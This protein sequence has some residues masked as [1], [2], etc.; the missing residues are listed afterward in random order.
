MQH[1]AS[2]NAQTDR[3]RTGRRPVLAAATTAGLLG[4]ASLT[5][6]PALAEQQKEQTPTPGTS[7]QPVVVVMD[8]SESMLEKDADEKG[9]ARI[10]A[11][12]DATKDL[13]EKTPEDAKLGM[14]AF[15]HAD[16]NT[17]TKI[18]TLQ[19][20]AKVDAKKLTKKVDALDAQGGTPLG[21]SLQH[22]ADELKD[23]EGEKSIVLVSDGE[24]TCD[25]P[26]ACEIAQQLAE[27]GIDLTVHTIGFR[28]QGNTKAQETLECIAEATGGTYSSAD[29]AEQLTETLTTQTTRALQGY[30]TAGTPVEGGAS[31]EDAPR[32]SA[33]QFTDTIATQK[34]E[35]DDGEESASRRYYRIPYHKGYTPVVTATVVKDRET[36]EMLG[37]SDVLIR[38]VDLSER[39]YETCTAL[40]DTVVPSRGSGLH[41]TVHWFEHDVFSKELSEDTRDNCLTKDDEVVV[42]V[43]HAA[44]TASDEEIPLE[45]MV[46]YAKQEK[47]SGS[48][49]PSPKFK[50]VKT[51]KAEQV[52]GGGSFNDATPIESG[53]TITDTLVPGEAKYFQIDAATNQTLAARVD[54]TSDQEDNLM[55]WALAYNPLREHMSFT[56]DPDAGGSGVD[57]TGDLSIIGPGEGSYANG[58]LEE[59]I[60]PNRR[61][62]SGG[63]EAYSVP[64][65]QYIKVQRE[66]DSSAADVPQS[67]E[68]TVDVR[69]EAEKEAGEFITTNAEYTEAFGEDSDTGREEGA[70]REDET[71]REE[72]TERDDADESDDT[73]REEDAESSDEA[74]DTDR[75]EESEPSPSEASGSEDGEEPSSGTDEQK[76]KDTEADVQAAE[77]QDSGDI[78]GILPWA[79]GG[80][81]VIALAGGGII[82]AGRRG[83]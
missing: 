82:L 79:I 60:H 23:V 4:L 75:E 62:S 1:Q 26:P 7:Q 20:V 74:E 31:P 49:A 69:G 61:I 24:P 22:A 72:D 3:T 53:Q 15:G 5:A 48:P 12:K 32:M 41:A 35:S 28:L 52:A 33:G 46:A 58:V 18:E 59:H 65:G 43:M 54:I 16:R 25:E 8:Y 47:A 64:G 55:I 68:L 76:D 6:A 78:S 80:L 73:E 39:P 66:Y 42:E 34:G 38:P 81:G 51:G 67:F 9:T 57:G 56:S 63:A 27:D 36:H 71:D 70:D 44:D 29:D 37:G 2:T 10:D 77:S 50:D 19:K 30:E 40:R 13:I 11:A 14:V 21:Q 17:C 83:A 45:L